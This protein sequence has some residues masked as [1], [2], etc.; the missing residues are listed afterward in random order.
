MK[1]KAGIKSKGKSSWFSPCSATDL[2]CDYGGIAAA[3]S[4]REGVTSIAR[5]GGRFLER[6]TFGLVRMLFISEKIHECGKCS[7]CLK[8]MLGSLDPSSP[9][10]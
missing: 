4:V 8:N 1:F 2:V 10:S 3:A 6:Q 7:F 9:G 5:W